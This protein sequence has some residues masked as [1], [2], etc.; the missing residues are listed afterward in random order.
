MLTVNPIDQLSQLGRNAVIIQRAVDPGGLGLRFDQRVGT[1]IAWRSSG[2]MDKRNLRIAVG[3]VVARSGPLARPRIRHGLHLDRL[4]KLQD[5][6][7]TVLHELAHFLTGQK[8]PTSDGSELDRKT[9]LGLSRYVIP[10]INSLWRFRDR[11]R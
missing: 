10:L 5:Y 2:C 11:L 4:P 9:D 8:P 1:A 7:G 3:R 6:L